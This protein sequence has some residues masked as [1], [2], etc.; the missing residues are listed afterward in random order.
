M[1]GAAAYFYCVFV[2]V[3]VME[4][5]T[6][7][8]VVGAAAAVC[9]IRLLRPGLSQYE[10]LFLIF[11]IGV[12][13]YMIWDRNSRFKLD[14]KETR[15][16]VGGVLDLVKQDGVDV[17]EFTLPIR[18]VLESDP[19]LLKAVVALTKYLSYDKDI[20]HAIIKNLI[21]FYELYADMLLG[22]KDATR[23]IGSLLDIRQ[24]I[25]EQTHSLYVSM[26]NTKHS[27][28]F[29]YISLILQS[30]TYKSLN[31]LKNKYGTFQHEPPLA[32]NAVVDD[33]S[34]ELFV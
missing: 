24:R 1:R 22:V 2:A 10:R 20:V 26:P 32:L 30:S 27:K 18:K 13:G 17:K 29:E 4:I 23:H 25:M 11:I 33:G 12:L 28:V 5:T 14:V 3:V 19:V 21:K 6:F 16:K 31:V 15:D 8:F 7:L 9:V 34:F